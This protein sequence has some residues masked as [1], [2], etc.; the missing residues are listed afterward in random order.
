MWQ[1][2]LYCTARYTP[3]E[4]CCSFTVTRAL[5]LKQKSHLIESS[6]LHFIATFFPQKSVYKLGN[7]RRLLW[8]CKNMPECRMTQ[9]KKHITFPKRSDWL[10][11]PHKIKYAPGFFPGAKAFEVWSWPLNTIQCRVKNDWKYTTALPYTF[12]ARTAEPLAAFKF[13]LSCLLDL[14]PTI[15]LLL[16][17]LSWIWETWQ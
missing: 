17:S 8:Q 7:F 11:D 2:L 10:R 13:L 12:T 4:S 9:N 6:F 5:P 16:K 14:G 15:N 1:R 3:Q